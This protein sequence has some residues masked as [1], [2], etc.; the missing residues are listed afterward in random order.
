MYHLCHIQVTP[1]G[2]FMRM[3]R[4]IVLSAHGIG[5]S[6]ILAGGHRLNLG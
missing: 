3:G 2:S 1:S 5:D 6:T 4:N